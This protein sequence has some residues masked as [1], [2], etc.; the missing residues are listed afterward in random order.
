MMTHPGKKLS[1]MGN[2]IGQ[3]REWEIDNE[4]EWFL[5]EYE[6]HAKFQRCIAELN[7]IYLR[8]S[9]L[10]SEDDSWRGFE[11]IEPDDAEQSILSYRRVATD[12]SELIV[13]INFTP[14]VHRDFL[15]GTDKPGVYREIFNS[16]DTRF[17]GSGVVNAGLISS[18]PIA[19]SRCKNSIRISV[20][21]LA[22]VIFKAE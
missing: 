7:H 11:W 4:T 5:L 15:L 1:Y 18:M 6:T 9:A 10:W 19:V 13:L 21:P 22:A 16:D 14:E 20:P 17:G 8:E 12:S 2:E 3:F